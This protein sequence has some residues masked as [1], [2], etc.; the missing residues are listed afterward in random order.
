MEDKAASLSTGTRVT[1]H[2]RERERE[3]DKEK[4]DKEKGDKEKGDKE[5]GDEGGDR[6]IFKTE[7]HRSKVVLSL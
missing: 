5:K 4:G 7:K 2:Q 3:G 1:V 6:S